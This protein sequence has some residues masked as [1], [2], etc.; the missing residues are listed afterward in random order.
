[1]VLDNPNNTEALFSVGA[2]LASMG[3]LNLARETM[4]HVIAIDPD[5][6]Q[7]QYN[8]AYLLH[9]LGD[10]EKAIKSYE[11]A[12]EIS[13]D[14]VWSRIRMGDTYKEMGN[15]QD[16]YEC[17]RNASEVYE[18]KPKI[19]VNLE[20]PFKCFMAMADC[21]TLL[22]RAEEAKNQYVQATE[23][24]PKSFDAQFELAKAYHAL[25]K[26]RQALDIFQKI[27]SWDEKVIDLHCFM[28]SCFFGLQLSQ[29]GERELVLFER[30]KAANPQLSKILTYAKKD[31]QTGLVIIWTQGTSP[32]NKYAA[33]IPSEKI[34]IPL[35]I[36]DIFEDLLSYLRYFATNMNLINALI[37][38]GSQISSPKVNPR[39]MLKETSN[40][41][42]SLKGNPAP[43]KHREIADY[44]QTKYLS[45]TS[46]IAVNE[47]DFG[48][49]KIIFDALRRLF[50][51]PNTTLIQDFADT[52]HGFPFA[53]RNTQFDRGQYFI[54][55]IQPFMERWAGFFTDAETRAILAW[56]GIIGPTYKRDRLQS[57]AKYAGHVFI[58]VTSDGT[59]RDGHRRIKA[60]ID[61]KQTVNTVVIP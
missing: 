33:A 27:L 14:H 23:I 52:F 20:I 55:Y 25:G 54:D 9:D 13:P 49:F 46:G 60:A 51:S 15:I 57:A 35:G 5:H 34:H 28:A 58:K 37:E 8:L 36:L 17:Y 2:C 4:E 39:T 45:R 18:K 21:L 50:V 59:V 29:E 3:K 38:I 12:L 61:A 10:Y 47:S 42:E 1:M 7:A 44:L 32:K 43:G 6:L 26:Y 30:L 56:K 11:R 31:N 16:A 53:V 41:L 48:I 22:G 40:I 24:A 19:S